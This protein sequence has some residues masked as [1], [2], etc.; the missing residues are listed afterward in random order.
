LFTTLSLEG[1]VAEVSDTHIKGYSSRYHF[2]HCQR[3]H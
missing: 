2:V 1:T 3:R